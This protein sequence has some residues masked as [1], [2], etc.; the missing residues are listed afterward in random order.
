MARSL[1][2]VPKLLTFTLYLSQCSAPPYLPLVYQKLLGFTSADV[3]VLACIPPFVAVFAGPF[4]SFVADI[5][6]RPKLM[7]ALTN[8]LTSALLW[9]FVSVEL[10][11]PA[12]CGLIVCYAFVSAPIGSLMDVTILNMLGEERELYGQQRLFGSISCGFCTFALGL[13]IEKLNGN[14][15]VAFLGHSIFVMMFVTLMGIVARPQKAPRF[16]SKKAEDGLPVKDKNVLRS[17]EEDPDRTAEELP[18]SDVTTGGGV[19]KPKRRVSIAP[20]AKNP[21]SLRRKSTIII[22]PPPPEGNTFKWLMAPD[23]IA[24]YFAVT[25]V[26]GVLSG[27][28]NFLWI[29]MSDELKAPTT[30]LGL[31]GPAQVVLQIPFFFF[32]KQ[33]LEKV[34]IRNTILLAHVLLIARCLIYTVLKAGPTMWAIILPELL[35]GAVFSGLWAAAVAYSVEVAPRGMEFLAQGILGAFYGGLGSGVG[36]L[37]SG[38]VYNKYKARW[39]FRGM[40]GVVLI[41][42]IVYAAVPTRR[43]T[44][45]QRVPEAEKRLDKQASEKLLDV[46]LGGVGGGGVAAFLA[47]EDA[48]S[49]EPRVPISMSRR[50]SVTAAVA[51]EAMARNRSMA[52]LGI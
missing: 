38:M 32:S 44:K 47:D 40:A 26:G 6:G 10:T 49:E 1:H 48:V 41:S 4:L 39:L 30:L 24:F 50:V 15:K 14:L 31:T 36:S 7:L 51:L 25:L 20:S 9:V 17:V 29:F 28:G 27:I 13:I 35:H 45:T 21:A 8:I 18:M 16:D 2:L 3:G 33:M 23:V 34:G 37:V 42:L 5:S 43:P 12:T 22:P 46:E 19:D 52:G 11:F